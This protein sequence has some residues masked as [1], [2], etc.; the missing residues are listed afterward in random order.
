MGGIPK[1]TWIDG[2][3]LTS[4]KTMDLLNGRLE[5][6]DDRLVKQTPHCAFWSRARDEASAVG[7]ALLRAPATAPAL[8]SLVSRRSRGRC[9]RAGSLPRLRARY[10]KPLDFLRNL[11]AQRVTIA[12]L[13]PRFAYEVL[14]VFYA[15]PIY[16][17]QAEVAAPTWTWFRVLEHGEL[18]WAQRTGA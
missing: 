9:A 15:E 5:L 17:H 6:V 12:L 14:E 7:R 10:N 13:A 3:I 11:L 8:V 16:R 18:C 2:I 4:P 1:E